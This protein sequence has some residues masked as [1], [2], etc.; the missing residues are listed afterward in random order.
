[1]NWVEALIFNVFT[2][3]TYWEFNELFEDY[4]SC[5]CINCIRM[6]FDVVFLTNFLGLSEIIEHGSNCWI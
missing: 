1:M 3:S 4:S 5:S 2:Y 6:I